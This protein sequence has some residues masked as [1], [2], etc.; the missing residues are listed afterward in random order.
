[1]QNLSA[2]QLETTL[3]D[4]TTD[5]NLCQCVFADC[6]VSSCYFNGYFIS[7]L[8]SLCR[9]VKYEMRN[10]LKRTW[11]AK[12]LIWCVIYM[13]AIDFWF[14]VMSNWVSEWVMMVTMIKHI[15]FNAIAGVKGVHKKMDKSGKD[16]LSY[17]FICV[18]VSISS[19]TLQN[20]YQNA[21]KN[22]WIKWW[23]SRWV[24]EN[25][26][27]IVYSFLWMRLFSV[28]FLFIFFFS[29]EWWE[30]VQAIAHTHDQT[31]WWSAFNAEVGANE[32]LL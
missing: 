6:T 9:K 25:K 14:I 16:E 12:N 26:K 18:C 17:A 20:C 23:I 24:P 10:D 7:F 31:K 19:Q 2:F 8:H 27:K 28:D 22:I 11:I 21:F 3:F 4:F 32:I 29:F 15:E 13:D 5:I 1:M 30:T